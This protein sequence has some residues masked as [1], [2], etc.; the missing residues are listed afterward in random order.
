MSKGKFDGWLICSD[1]DGTLTDNKGIIS[2][3]NIEAI[4]YFQSEGG[5]FTVATGRYSDFVRKFAPDFV[6]NTYI[7]GLNGAVITDPTGENERWFADMPKET[8]KDIGYLFESCPQLG[9]L[10]LNLQNE[11]IEYTPDNASDA[12]NAGV[13]EDNKLY[14]LVFTSHEI[15]TDETRRIFDKYA[16]G[17][18]LCEQSWQ[19]GIELYALGAG[20]RNA[21]AELK[22]L[23][24]AEHLICVG[25]W[26]NDIGMLEIADIGFAVANAR[27]DVKRAADIVT[28]SN[29][30]SAIAKVIKKI[31]EITSGGRNEKL[32]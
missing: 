22:R 23:T 20:K 17:R 25:D 27:D 11:C 12:R 13:S 1:I 15:I 6:P 5:M 3:E 4:R 31:Q 24:G 14:K 28:V 19:F 8:L 2:P 10:Y 32:H 29:N 7:V 18:Y 26:E 30:E 9:H 21:V 16:K